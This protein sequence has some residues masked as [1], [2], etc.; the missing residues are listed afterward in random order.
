MHALYT[1]YMGEIN[2]L[3]DEKQSIPYRGKKQKKKKTRLNRLDEKRDV[4]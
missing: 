1:H 4:E 3:G 2:F